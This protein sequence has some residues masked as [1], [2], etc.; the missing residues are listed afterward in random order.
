MEASLYAGRTPGSPLLTKDKSR[1]QY[2]QCEDRA[3]DN[4]EDEVISGVD[5]HGG[6][7]GHSDHLN[8][9]DLN[10]DGHLKHVGG[11]SHDGDGIHDDNSDWS[12][13]SDGDTSV[14]LERR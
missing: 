7:D 6:H 12:D 4:S 8:E 10:Q 14:M 11:V 5:L 2:W 1:G 3:E 13:I 9:G